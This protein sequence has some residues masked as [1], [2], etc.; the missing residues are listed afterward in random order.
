MVLGD[1]YIKSSRAILSSEPHNFQHLK[2]G[3][4]VSG[5]AFREVVQNV[6]K[7]IISG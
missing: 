6:E 5:T 2:L 4:V 7:V 3:V 1:I